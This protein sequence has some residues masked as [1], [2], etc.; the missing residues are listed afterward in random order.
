MARKHYKSQEWGND[1]V[2]PLKGPKGDTAFL[3]SNYKFS[4]IGS[5]FRTPKKRFTP[6]HIHDGAKKAGFIVR[7]DDEAPWWKV[8]VTARIPPERKSP[9]PAPPKQDFYHGAGKQYPPL[10]L[11]DPTPKKP[12]TD[13]FS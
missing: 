8:T 9:S 5:I 13:I 1:N 2:D 7:V 10:E 4:T 6:R 11:I 12:I 3:R